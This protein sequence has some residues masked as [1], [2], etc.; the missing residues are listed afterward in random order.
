M[1]RPRAVL[2]DLGDT[3]LREVRYDIA[4]GLRAVVTD[5]ARVERLTQLLSDELRRE[6]AEH[7]DLL[8][9][10]WVREKV[11][12]LH[13]TS[14]ESIE[15]GIWD[16][17]VTLQPTEG[18]TTVLDRLKRDGVAMAVVSNAS[19]SARALRRELDRHALAGFFTNVISSGDLRLRKPNR[20]LFDEPL[21]ELGISASDAW[22]VG[23]SFAEDMVGAR[24]AGLIAVW[25]SAMADDRRLPPGVIRVED[26]QQ[27][28]LRYEER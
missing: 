14:V 22:F 10:E 12:E 18:V 4:M 3:I 16:A 20:L 7:R 17:I 5:E 1:K 21:R 15:N 6:Y 19:F 25:R 13:E 8:I 24:H 2:F 26:W 23:D 9:A 28:L 11:A 27:F